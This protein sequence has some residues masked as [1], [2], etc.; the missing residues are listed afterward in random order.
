MNLK[1]YAILAASLLTCGS[2]LADDVNYHGFHINASQELI[3]NDTETALPTSV[4]NVGGMMTL[5]AIYQPDYHPIMVDASFNKVSDATTVLG[6][7]GKL[8]D[9]AAPYQSGTTFYTPG[10][11][12]TEGKIDGAVLEFEMG[13]DGLAYVTSPTQYYKGGVLTDAPAEG[14]DIRVRFCTR[15][16][17]DSSAS[18]IGD[19][20]GCRADD[21]TG[22]FVTVSAPANTAVESHY[23]QAN[24]TTTF[25][26]KAGGPND[27][28]LGKVQ[29]T[30]IFSLGST[31]KD[32]APEDIKSTEW[33]TNSWNLF[34]YKRTDND[35]WGFPIRFVDIVFKG[36]KPGEKVGW[37]NYQGLHEGYTPTTYQQLV[38][39]S[40]ANVGVDADSNA[41]VE[42]FNLQGVRV[43]NPTTGLYIQRQGAK[44]TKVLVK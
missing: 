22:V 32:N 6:A 24:M 2:M 38:A 41:A 18:R 30:A 37:T 5:Q 31:T 25:T 4:W 3:D 35:T 7:A 11:S 39:S 1:L 13:E 27:D 21:I 36:V 17:G 12:M 42:Y 9:Y 23:V 28:A 29:R 19:T 8:I 10:E 40:V 16:S 33:A 43:D 14:G 44:A 15:N 26:A 34:T 20:E